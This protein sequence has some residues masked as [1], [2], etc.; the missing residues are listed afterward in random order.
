M[1]LYESPSARDA[2]QPRPTTPTL[3]ATPPPLPV[4]L[5]VPRWGDA[6]QEPAAAPAPAAVPGVCSKRPWRRFLARLT[7]AALIVA[8]AAPWVIRWRPWH[9]LGETG[10][11]SGFTLDAHEVDPTPDP[12]GPAAVETNTAAPASPLPPPPTPAPPSSGKVAHL[13]PYIIPLKNEDGGAP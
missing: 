2:G 9:L 13:E 5:R 8:A 3:P 6:A 10:L 7:L 4:V 11:L 12:D 1:S